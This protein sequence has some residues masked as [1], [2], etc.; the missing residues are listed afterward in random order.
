[1]RL[2]I[3]LFSVA[4][5][6]CGTIQITDGP[7]G[8]STNPQIEQARVIQSKASIFGELLGGETESCAAL[9]TETSLLEVVEMNYENGTCTVTLRR[10]I[11]GP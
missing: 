7:F 6:G 1:M 10:P 4:L 9:A 11:D 2:A 3:L 8:L 5:S